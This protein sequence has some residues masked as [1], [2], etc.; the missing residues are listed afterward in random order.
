MIGGFSPWNN[1]IWNHFINGMCLPNSGNR[2]PLWSK[3]I[4]LKVASE[5]EAYFWIETFFPNAEYATVP[6]LSDCVPSF[7]SRAPCRSWPRD[8]DAIGPL[9]P[10]PVAVRF[11]IR[12]Q[13]IVSLNFR[14]PA[15]LT[16]SRFF[17]SVAIHLQHWKPCETKYE[18]ANGK[19]LCILQTFI[20][21]VFR[22]SPPKKFILKFSPSTS[23]C[24]TVWVVGPML[25]I[26][27]TN[28]TCYCIMTNS[29]YEK[30]HCCI[31]V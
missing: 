3:C 24:S 5:F 11:Y 10:W 26:T 27:G 6:H 12:T 19:G 29:L 13:F 23:N 17:S 14:C 31:S 8:I 25:G 20:L 28:K 18:D 21:P 22:I 16:S 9:H 30:K 4:L 2:R 15:A 1:S 7:G